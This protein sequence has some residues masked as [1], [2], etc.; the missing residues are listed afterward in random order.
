MIF[1]TAIEV[2][3]GSLTLYFLATQFIIPLWRDTPIFPIFEKER[4]LANRRAKASQDVL[5]AKL[6]Q[7]IRT[8]TKEAK[9][10]RTTQKGDENA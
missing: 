1:L 8:I 7:E 2:L 5:E 4:T 10:L 6:E 3:I 9:K